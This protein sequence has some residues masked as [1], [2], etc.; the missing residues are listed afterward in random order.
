MDFT[1]GGDILTTGFIIGVGNNQLVVSAVTN[2]RIRVFGWTCGSETGAR[3]TFQF[4][5]N[6]GGTLISGLIGVP[7]NT[8]ADS[9]MPI[10]GPGLFET[11]T[12]EALYVDNGLAQSHFNIFYK[13]YTP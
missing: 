1:R 9:I 4:K 3:S 7:P 10:Q 12:G 11:N 8:L 13:V 5:S 2:Q 6:S